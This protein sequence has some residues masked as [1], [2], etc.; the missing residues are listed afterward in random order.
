M[1]ACCLR[2]HAS[3]TV[4]RVAVGLYLAP[5]KP[6]SMCMPY[7]NDD[8]NLFK[9]NVPQPADWLRAWRACRAPSSFQ[10]AVQFFGTEDFVT[11][12]QQRIKVP[13]SL[14]LTTF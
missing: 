9:G 5:E 2:Q 3:C 8:Q 4:H 1:Q 14:V 12:R 6:I 10:A 13:S 7:S 11:G